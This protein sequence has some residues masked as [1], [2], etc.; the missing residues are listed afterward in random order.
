MGQTTVPGRK[1]PPKKPMKKKGKAKGKRLMAIDGELGTELAIP[2]KQS[3]LCRVL[4]LDEQPATAEAK[5]KLL[6]QKMRDVD[7]IVA[8]AEAK[9]KATKRFAVEAEQEFEAASKRVE[10]A[11]QRENQM[12]E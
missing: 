7:A 8:E 11:K 6:Q 4:G 12:I 10:Q 5:F 2:K 9:E 1:M 3:A